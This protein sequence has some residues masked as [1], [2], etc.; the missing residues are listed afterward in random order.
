MWLELWVGRET[1]RHILNVFN[2][3]RKWRKF[4]SFKSSTWILKSSINIRST[5]DEIWNSSKDSNSMKNV[6]MD[7]DGGRNTI[8]SLN[9]LFYD[10]MTEPMHSNAEKTGVN[11]KIRWT[12]FWL[13]L[14]TPPS[15]D[16]WGL[17]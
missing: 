10:V 12:D 13:I 1:C 4:E 3:L 7:D 6:D 8:K 5:L 17:P 2:S 16:V 14:A 15:R 11:T 9:E